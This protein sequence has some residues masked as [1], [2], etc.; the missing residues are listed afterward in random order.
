MF[1]LRDVSYRSHV[2]ALYARSKSHHLRSCGQPAADGETNRQHFPFCSLSFA[3]RFLCG[4]PHRLRF[5]VDFCVPYRYDVIGRRP[6]GKRAMSLLSFYELF[7]VSMLERMPE[8]IKLFSLR[9][10]RAA[11]AAGEACTSPVTEANNVDE[12]NH[13]FERRLK[14]NEASPHGKRANCRIR[15]RYRNYPTAHASGSRVQPGACAG[16]QRRCH[17]RH[18]IPELRLCVNP[19]CA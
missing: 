7:P 14:T 9:A 10:C 6:G 11:P 8:A 15:W 1:R 3:S 5:C 13:Y 4:S 16:E 18:F 19:G 12:K 2:E 17:L